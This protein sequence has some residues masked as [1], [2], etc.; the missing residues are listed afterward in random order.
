MKIHWR[1]VISNYLLSSEIGSPAER[2]RDKPSLLKNSRVRSGKSLF[3]N[4]QTK[5]WQVQ[6]FLCQ[7]Q[8]VV[9]II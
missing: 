2:A 6:N 5:E 7:R 8:C 9:L 1:V 3:G 4:N